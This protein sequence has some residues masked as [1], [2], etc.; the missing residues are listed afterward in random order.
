[1][2]TRDER[3]SRRGG[4]GLGLVSM[5]RRPEKKSE[6]DRRKERKGRRNGRLVTW[7]SEDQ[8]ILPP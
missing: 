7:L 6:K 4:Q 1:M 2:M 5:A 8:Q 3:Q